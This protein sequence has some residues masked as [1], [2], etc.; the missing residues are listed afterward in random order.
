MVKNFQKIF[1]VGSPG[2]GKTTLAQKLSKKLNIPHF[3]LDDIRYP[4]SQQKTLDIQAIPLV[5]RIV[6][7]NSWIIDGIY[8]AW[9]KECLKQTELI[10][11]LDTP[12]RVAFYRIFIR[13]IKNFLRRKLRH[14]IK[15]TLILIKN[16]ARYHFPKPG[17][18]LNDEDE[19]I[20]RYKTATV[21]A[22]YKE[23]VV[24]IKNNQDLRKFLETVST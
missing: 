12:F 9:V 10:I 4:E 1:I 23:K 5:N 8:I 2:A 17:T 20:T 14:G 15:S 16:L 21:L 7:K 13:F 24:W 6:Q 18:E 3:D 22:N 19:Y 11:W